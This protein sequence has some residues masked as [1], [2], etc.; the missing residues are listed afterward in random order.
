MSF[1]NKEDR[2]KCWNYRDEYWKCLDDG[3]SETECK[4]FRDQY[5]KFCPA[6]WVKHFDRKRE[7][8]KFKEQIEQG[9]TCSIDGSRTEKADS[10]AQVAAKATFDFQ[11]TST[12]SYD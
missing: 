1:P 4:R 8:L 5:E 2:T 7:Y 6:L 11:T 12:H 3:K 9:G 10:P